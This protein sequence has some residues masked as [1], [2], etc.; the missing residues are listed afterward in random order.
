MIGLGEVVPDFL[1]A[2]LRSD[3]A[4]VPV[5][6]L[7]AVTYPLILRAWEI[8]SRFSISHW[9]ASIIAAAQELGCQTLYT[10]DLGHGQDYDG[11]RVVN[12]FLGI[13]G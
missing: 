13:G 5:Y 2:S 6:Q 8:R 3:H 9:D 11:V 1:R 4:T 7:Q 10:E 12:P